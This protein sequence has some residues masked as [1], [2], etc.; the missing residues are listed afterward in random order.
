MFINDVHWS[1]STC[2]ILYQRTTAGRVNS[3]TCPTTRDSANC[4][5]RQSADEMT[6]RIV[7]FVE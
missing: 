2:F 6:A 1:L 3:A 4:A 5:A 7:R